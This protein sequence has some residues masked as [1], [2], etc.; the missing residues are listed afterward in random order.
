[1]KTDTISEHDLHLDLPVAAS[2]E[3][4]RDAIDRVED[5]WS[6]ALERSGDEFT[7]YFDRNWTR[8]RVDGARWKITGQDT[9]ALPIADEWVGDDLTFAVEDTGAETSVLHFTHF[10]LLAHK[11]AADCQ[12]A[13][14]NFLASLVS[15][16]ETGE[17]NPWK[18]GL[19]A[20]GAA[21]T[22]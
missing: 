3:A 11:C 17:G 19:P 10:G 9:P 5:W 1:M 8:V 4:L 15:L 21:S 2:G 18:P 13:W 7:V 22:A 14:R 20:G 16:A 6:T 12:P